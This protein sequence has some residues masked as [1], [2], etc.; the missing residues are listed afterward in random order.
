MTEP[1]QNHESDQIPC[2]P[3]SEINR[4]LADLGVEEEDLIERFTLGEGSGGQKINKT[5]SCVQLRHIGLNIDIRCQD[6]RSRSRN[7]LLARE[8]LLEK[9]E[10]LNQQHSLAKKRRRAAQRAKHRKPGAA[11]K[12]RHREAKTRHSRKKDLRRKPSQD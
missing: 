3:L 7:R 1:S 10:E 4:R 6:S 5:H 12:K 2:D 11:A 8:R 9:I